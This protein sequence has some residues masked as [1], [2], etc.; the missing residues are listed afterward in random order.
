VMAGVFIGGIAF[1]SGL[2]ALL[3]VA[4]KSGDH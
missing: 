2:I 1:I 4:I 3:V